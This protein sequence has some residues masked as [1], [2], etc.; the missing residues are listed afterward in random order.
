MYKTKEKTRGYNQT[1][2]IA[3][4]LAKII[5]TPVLDMLQK[6]DNTESQTKKNIYQRWHNQEEKFRISKPIKLSGKHLL[7]I[8]DVITTGATMHNCLKVFHNK[9]ITLSVVCVAYS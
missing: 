1:N 2:I 8:D 3:F 9:N 4:E 5:N 7:I 6:I